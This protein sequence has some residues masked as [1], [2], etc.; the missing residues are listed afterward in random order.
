MQQLERI[1]TTDLYTIQN[2][3]LS[4]GAQFVGEEI[5]Q[6]SVSGGEINEVGHYF[7]A[8]KTGNIHIFQAF[9]NSYKAISGR[10]KVTKCLWA[11]IL[12]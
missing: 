2:N 5:E 9:P 6:C 10:K 4:F 11:R 1:Y 12:D 8:D 7:C 3:N